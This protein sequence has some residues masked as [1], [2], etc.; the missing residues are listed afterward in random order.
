MSYSNGCTARRTFQT[1]R[2][3][4]LSLRHPLRVQATTRGSHV[5]VVAPGLACQ[6]Q[7]V[8][9]RAAL[10]DLSAAIYALHLRLR[11]AEEE[12]LAEEDQDRKQ[13]LAWLLEPC[14]VRPEPPA[15]ED[16]IEAR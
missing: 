2:L 4:V 6:G 12:Q 10:V 13:R 3:G 14:P 5:T 8:D 9:L 16:P 15:V 11:H 1:V 7:G